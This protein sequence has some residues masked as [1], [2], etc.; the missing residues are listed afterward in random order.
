MPATGA[1]YL[2]STWENAP[3][4]FESSSRL[5]EGFVGAQ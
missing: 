2:F 4:H 5:L 1:S 3:N